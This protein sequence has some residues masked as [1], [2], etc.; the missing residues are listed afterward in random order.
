MKTFVPLHQ[1]GLLCALG[2]MA[3]SGLTV[4]T[5][6]ATAQTLQLRLPDIS[7]PGNRES[8]S[9][10][11][12]T[13]IA[14]NENLVA[15]MP[16]SNYGLTQSAYPTFYFYLPETTAEQVKFVLLNEA[17]NEFVYEG[18]FALESDG[19]IASVS[20]PNNGLQEPLAIGET[21]VWYISV[22]CD[23]LDPSADVVTEGQIERVPS[24]EI[25]EDTPVAALPGIY[26]EAGLWYDAIATS[27]ALKQADNQ[28]TDWNALLDAV[29][30]DELIPVN[31]LSSRLSQV[32]PVSTIE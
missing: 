32:N 26:A 11:S 18:R 5:L 6:P 30:L 12:T 15:L 20:L 3:G 2:L 19:G 28:T 1:A 22:V 27:A 4:T 21:Y 13:C 25:A 24:L 16:E 9:T 10:R 17:T 31:L 8:G 14:A 23:P 7:A 29:E